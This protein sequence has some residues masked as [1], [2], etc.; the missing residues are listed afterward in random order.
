MDT[1]KDKNHFKEK[2]QKL[3]ATIEEYENRETT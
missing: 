1:K 2:E 3:I